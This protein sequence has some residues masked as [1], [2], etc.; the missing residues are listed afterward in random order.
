M[1]VYRAVS[2]NRLNMSGL[3][4]LT[5]FTV[6]TGLAAFPV[7]SHSYVSMNDV[8]NHVARA[9]VLAHYNDMPGLRDYW[10]PNWRLVPYLGYDIVQV[11]LPSWFSMGLVVKLMIGATFMALIGGAMLLSR[12]AHGTWSAVS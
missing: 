3:I 9:A 7:F 2:R 11:W 5:A 12:A 10:T 8:Y 1:T 4:A 6:A